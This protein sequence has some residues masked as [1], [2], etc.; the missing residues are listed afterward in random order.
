MRLIWYAF[1]LELILAS[2]QMVQVCTLSLL[3]SYKEF[4]NKI[5][6][7]LKF[8][9]FVNKINKRKNERL[10]QQTCSDFLSN[11][12]VYSGANRKF[13]LSMKLAINAHFY[14]T[15]RITF[16]AC[17]SMLKTTNNR[18]PWKW[19]LFFVLRRTSFE[20]QD[21]AWLVFQR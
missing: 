19:K 21:L 18:I 16:S 12:F 1:K 8:N 2:Y 10:K 14:V 11:S 15:I 5:I 3:F 20:A 4:I 9:F 7:I 6:Y 17:T 13:S